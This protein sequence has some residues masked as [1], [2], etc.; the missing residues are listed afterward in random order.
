M[1][2]KTKHEEAPH[3]ERAALP[4]SKADNER[5]S[6]KRLDNSALNQQYINNQQYVKDQH[7]SEL[8]ALPL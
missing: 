5:L 2:K 3:M 7:K 4:P 1:K 6:I 8:T